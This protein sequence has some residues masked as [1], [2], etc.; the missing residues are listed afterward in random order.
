MSLICCGICLLSVQVR[1]VMC[2]DFKP[3]DLSWMFISQSHS[4][5]GG[6][7]QSTFLYILYVSSHLCF[8]YGSVI[9]LLKTTSSNFDICVSSGLF[10]LGVP[11]PTKFCF[12]YM[13]GNLF[14]KYSISK[15]H[16]SREKNVQIA[17][18]LLNSHLS[19]CNW[20][21]PTCCI[22]L[23]SEASI[24]TLVLTLTS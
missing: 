8:E 12:F 21:H 20:C 11:P 14:K 19:F 24:E 17:E 16:N 4:P 15:K 23:S 5:L 7:S 10:S 1:A 22:G 9:I 18:F 13:P 6:S 2:C 3:S